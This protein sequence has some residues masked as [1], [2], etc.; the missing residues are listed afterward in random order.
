VVAES[1]HSSIMILPATHF[2]CTVIHSFIILHH[3][4]AL[5][6]GQSPHPVTD[7]CPLADRFLLYVF[8]S[9]TA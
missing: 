6:W 5:F 7:V 1:V 8:V 3:M 9:L 4:T 2:P